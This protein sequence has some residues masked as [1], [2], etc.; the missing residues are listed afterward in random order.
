MSALRLN[1]KDARLLHNFAVFVDKCRHDSAAAEE[2]YV[3]ARPGVPRRMQHAPSTRL[4]RRDRVV[5][6]VGSSLHAAPHA[7]YGAPEP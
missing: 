1:P 3:K 6:R 4:V 5:P 2:H 7:T